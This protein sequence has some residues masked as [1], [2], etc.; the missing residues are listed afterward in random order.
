VGS[1]VAC[2]TCCNS[3]TT[4]LKPEPGKRPSTRPC[5][6]PIVSTILS[7]SNR[8]YLATASCMSLSEP[9]FLGAGK[10]GG[11]RRTF[12]GSQLKRIKERKLSG[13]EMALEKF[14]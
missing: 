10:Q 12:V 1:R 4:L 9:R 14:N 11:W 6:L 13:F 8:R 3:A 2:D 7:G 5:R